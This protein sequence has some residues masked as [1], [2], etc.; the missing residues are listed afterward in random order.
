MLSKL[1]IL[2]RRHYKSRAQRKGK[3]MTPI[4]TTAGG[5]KG[6][7]PPRTQTGP[8]KLTACG[9]RGT[10]TREGLQASLLVYGGAIAVR[11]LVKVWARLQAR[12]DVDPTTG[13]LLLAGAVLAAGFVAFLLRKLF[14]LTD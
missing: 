12:P 13:P 2:T 6:L 4:E 5:E 1:D 7:P 9:P 14:A 11:V 10:L 8:M 3:A